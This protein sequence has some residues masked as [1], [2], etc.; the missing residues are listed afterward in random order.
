VEGY[1]RSPETPRVNGAP[2]AG[3]ALDE[4]S[5]FLRQLIPFPSSE[6]VGPL[7]LLP[8]PAQ[9]SAAQSN[10][11]DSA[12]A[13][14]GE[15]ATSIVSQAASVLDEEMARGVLAAR[16]GA[17]TAPHGYSNA[18]HPV[19][20]QMHEFVDNLAALWPSLQGGAAK[21]PST[22]QL[23]TSDAEPLA[24][25]RPRATVKPGE[26]ATI[27][28][29]LRNS[30]SQPV[31]LVP[32]ATDLL[33]SRG[34]RIPNSLLEFTPSEIALEPQ[35]QKDLSISTT[36]PVEAAPGCYSGLLVV[37]GLDYLRALITIEVA[38]TTA[39][40]ESLQTPS[41]P[42]TAVTPSLTPSSMSS[43][44][45][46]RVHNPKSNPYWRGSGAGLA[47]RQ[48]WTGMLPATRY[49]SI[50]QEA[51]KLAEDGEL[52]NSDAIRLLQMPHRPEDVKEVLA[53]FEKQLTREAKSKLILDAFV[54]LPAGVDN[55]RWEPIFDRYP[56]TG[57]MYT[58]ASDTVVSNEVQYYNGEMVQ[59]YGGCAN[60]AGV[61]E[62]LAGSG[63]KPMTMMLADGQES[64]IVQF[65]SHQ[66]TDT[67][68]RP[69]NAMFVIVAA[70]RDD[71]PA[72][73][74]CIRADENEA[75][76][77]LSMFDGCFDPTRRA[78]ENK[79]QLC[80]VRLLDS[81]RVAIEVGRERM[82]TDKRPGTIEL[83]HE[84]QQ[85]TFS[86]KDGAGR[87]VAQI[88]F[89]P[90]DDPSAYLSELAKAA[91]TAGIP[92]RELPCGTEYVYPGVARIGT[93]PVVQWQWRTD[94]I[95][96]FQPVKP[97]TV[98]FDASS[99]EGNTLIKWGFEPKVLGYIPNVRG[100]VT[101]IPESD[102]SRQAKVGIEEP[103]GVVVLRPRHW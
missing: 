49:N 80:F 102:S 34:G 21:G 29:T 68:L 74:A 4:A 86:I 69:Y 73:Q 14:V 6:S 11:V 79:A 15:P 65:W 52:G 36:V 47:P 59:L 38:S 3:Q 30:E 48:E 62:A 7:S 27:S 67:S 2:D 85:R 17:G 41:P 94:V 87:A 13:T 57:K 82:G 26:R 28:M 64:A 72:S 40:P 88:K 39:A 75:S 12:A 37:R 101:G 10:I 20:R 44:T 45:V 99:E 9:G 63:Y 103:K 89:V 93:G 46:P 51:I 71:T 53:K 81:T 18:S 19:L 55:Q 97:D 76:S 96:R 84:G 70:V 66:L 25:L 42:R 100:A 77:V 95:P 83:R 24:T 58:T 54:P 61:R 60:I 8:M 23:A 50:M 32:T 43:A 91:A 92:L 98:V 56:I 90:A 16:S 78:Y 35:E 1:R 5:A 31:R 22:D 33:G